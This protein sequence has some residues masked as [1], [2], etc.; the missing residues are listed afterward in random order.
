MNL[1]QLS[2]EDLN[3]KRDRR[4]SLCSHY[5]DLSRGKASKDFVESCKMLNLIEKE[6]KKRK[7]WTPAY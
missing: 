6:L 2:D 4:H 5:L 7:I 3:T 1:T